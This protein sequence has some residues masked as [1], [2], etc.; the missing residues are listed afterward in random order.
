M[1]YLKDYNTITW[2]GI[3]VDTKDN[4]KEEC[5]LEEICKFIKL[6]IR[7]YNLRVV[8]RSIEP[9]SPLI[10]NDNSRVYVLEG[11][12]LKALILNKDSEVGKVINL[13]TVKLDAKTDRADGEVF[14]AMGGILIHIIEQFSTGVKN[15]VYY[16]N[17]NSLSLI[18]ADNDFYYKKGSPIPKL[19]AKKGKIYLGTEVLDI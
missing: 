15:S 9:T 12:E 5:T 6:G 8:D 10:F 19:N 2:K 7:I 18:K 3:I 13:G 11:S 17:G 14:N 4:S 1:F 16:F